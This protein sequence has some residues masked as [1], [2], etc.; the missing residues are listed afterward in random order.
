MICHG[1]CH[2][3]RVKCPTP[4]ACEIQDEDPDFYGFDWWRGIIVDGLLVLALTTGI[5]VLV[6]AIA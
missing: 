1:P 2:Q 4:H 6:L 5:V 3:G